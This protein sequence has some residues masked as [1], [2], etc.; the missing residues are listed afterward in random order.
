VSE[1][2]LQVTVD[3]FIFRVKTGFLY[4]QDGVWLAMD[5]ASGVARAGLT[6]FRQQASGDLAF[7]D[8]PP[9]GQ[10]VAPGDELANIETVKVDLDVPA[11]I[12]GEIMATNDALRETPELVNQDPYGE[13]WLVELKPVRW[14][15]EGLL[16]AHAYLAVMTQQAQE[17]ANK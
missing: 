3:K 6:D 12:S 9:V 5:E 1:E 2:Y 4:T 10:Q 17:E 7:V 13:G 16:D 8:M 15:A 11:P 14:P